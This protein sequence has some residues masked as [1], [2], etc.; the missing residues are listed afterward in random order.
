M[1][2]TSPLR[3]LSQRQWK[4]NSDT[5]QH[6][7]IDSKLVI[8]LIPIVWVPLATDRAQVEDSD[9]P[10]QWVSAAISP[11]VAARGHG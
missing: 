8:T 6:L 7:G 5:G 1:L 3:S 4:T 9:F 10:A 2:E 11:T